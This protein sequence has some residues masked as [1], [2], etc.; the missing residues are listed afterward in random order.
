[1]STSLENQND[2]YSS[3]QEEHQHSIQENNHKSSVE[4][5]QGT[6]YSSETGIGLI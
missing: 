5:L 6:L 3:F 2:Q 1:M 4:D